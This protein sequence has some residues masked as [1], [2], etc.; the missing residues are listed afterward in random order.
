[1]LH[2][3]QNHEHS[4]CVISLCAGLDLYAKHKYKIDTAE[5]LLNYPMPKEHHII[6]FFASFYW[7]QRC[8][9]SQVSKYAVASYVLIWEEFGKLFFN[10]SY[11]S[12]V[13][14]G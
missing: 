12:V 3:S 9:F 1:M 6:F 13:F 8:N 10:L 2:L 5:S 7:Q 14:H 4:S 11:P